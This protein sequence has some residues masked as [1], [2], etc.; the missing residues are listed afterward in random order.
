M[1][2][3]EGRNFSWAA[4]AAITENSITLFFYLVD[5][6]ESKQ[7]KAPRQPHRGSL[8]AV[9]DHNL[10]ARIGYVQHDG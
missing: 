2:D 1:A 7:I 9:G 10:P 3:P 6:A 5:R 8:R 4:R